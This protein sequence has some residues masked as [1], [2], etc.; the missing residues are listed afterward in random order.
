MSLNTRHGKPVPVVIM[1]LLG[2]V[3]IMGFNG[4]GA[5]PACAGVQCAT[6]IT[7]API[8]TYSKHSRQ[9][10]GLSWYGLVRSCSMLPLWVESGALA[11]VES[12]GLVIAAGGVLSAPAAFVWALASGRR[13]LRF[14]LRPLCLSMHQTGSG[15]SGC[16]AC[17]HGEA[18]ES[19]PALWRI[20][21]M[22]IQICRHASQLLWVVPMLGVVV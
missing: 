6:A 18:G 16:S 15:L 8:A 22:W 7:A 11:L 3:L 4:V 19:L 2:L 10:S 20:S 9:V 17:P 14:M 5:L 1:P 21:R 12:M 13:G